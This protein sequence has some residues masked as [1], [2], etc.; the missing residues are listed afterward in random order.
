M[1]R[2]LS[3]LLLV[4]FSTQ[5]FALS[6]N[7]V[8]RSYQACLS[9]LK[10]SPAQQKVVAKNS[11]YP[12]A[13]VMWACKFQARRSE[14]EMQANEREYQRQLR[15][16]GS[17]GGFYGG[18][19]NNSAEPAPRSRDVYGGQNI[20]PDGSHGTTCELSPDGTYHGHNLCPN[21]QYGTTCNICPDGSYGC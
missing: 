12:L 9:F 14:Q 6:R 2:L 13:S 8:R 17:S 4:A 18:N 15:N 11:G 1:F 21:G 3:L 19:G 16:G 10:L 7:E 20:C 5:A